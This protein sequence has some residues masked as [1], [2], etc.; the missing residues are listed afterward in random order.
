MSL[1]KKLKELRVQ[2]DLSQPQLAE[3]I[4]IEQSYLSKIENDKSI[5][6]NEIFRACLNAFNLSLDEFMSSIDNLEQQ[7]KLTEVPDIE[8]WLKNK[9]IH[10]A[11]SQRHFLYLSGLF[12]ALGICIF[13]MGYSKKI[14]D[15]TMFEY[16][17]PGIVLEGEPDNIFFNWRHLMESN[18][19]EDISARALEIER[20]KDM[21]VVLLP[22][23]T[24][25]QFEQNVEEGKRVFYFEKE[26]IV[27]R[28][29]NPWL[30]II[31][32]FLFVLGALGFV[33]ER[34]FFK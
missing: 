19:R 29:I 14:F 8:I 5:P 31:G 25:S 22:E 34:K 6:S 33:L 20:R 12:I 2:R 28:K 3:M 4:G 10:R 26:L 1:G 7:G 13:Y 24:D 11:K 16:R 32:I 9:Q 15:E 23:F 30:E 21:K 17:S 27:T 18:A